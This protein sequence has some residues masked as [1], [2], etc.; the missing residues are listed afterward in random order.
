SHGAPE[1]DDEARN[2]WAFKPVVR[3]AIPQVKR[4]QWV[5]NPID[6]FILSRLE[7]Q[8]FQPAAEAGRGSLLRR[9]HYAVT[10]LPPSP[11]E[12]EAFVADTPPDAYEKRVDALLAS[13]HYG[14]HWGR[15]WLDLVRYAE[16]NSFERDGAKA[17][18]W[19]YRDYVIQ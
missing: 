1:V 4:S 19:K 3:P 18:A 5:R 2:F 7:E 11:E 10:G 17:H 15:H 16:T 9:L 13:R 14:E 8:G 12:V 6:A